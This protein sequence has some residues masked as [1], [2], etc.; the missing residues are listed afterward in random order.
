MASRSMLNSTASNSLRDAFHEGV[1]LRDCHLD[2]FGGFCHHA[3]FLSAVLR[4]LA[5]HS[6]SASSTI[7]DTF[8]SSSTA[9]ILVVL[10]RSW[11]MITMSG[12]LPKEA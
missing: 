3:V 1:K 12:F 4:L 5:N 2:L 9:E 11:L 10:M 7:W 6:V 8:R